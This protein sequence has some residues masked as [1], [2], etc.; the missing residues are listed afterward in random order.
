MSRAS[1]K[2]GIVW[3]VFGIVNGIIR[4]LRTSHCPK[5]SRHDVVDICEVPQHA[6]GAAQSNGLS[7]EQLVGEPEDGHVRPA[8]WT[9]SGHCTQL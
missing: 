5:H 8:V 4:S 6:P 3:A 7:S 9:K 1:L 2:K